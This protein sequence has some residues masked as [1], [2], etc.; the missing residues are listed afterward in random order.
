MHFEI[1]F[2][3]NEKSSGYGHVQFISPTVFAMD[4][5]TLVDCVMLSHCHLG[6]CNNQEKTENAR[7]GYISYFCSLSKWPVCQREVRFFPRLTFCFQNQLT[8]AAECLLHLFFLWPSKMPAL[9]Q[10]A[11][12]SY[13]S[14]HSP[15]VL[16]HFLSWAIC[17]VFTY[18]LDCLW[19]IWPV[20][21]LIEF[22]SMI[23][24]FFLVRY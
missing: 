12:S 18:W 4:A 19:I 21:L 9:L 6:Q 11:V 2:N 23:S 16:A 1:C 13:F 15:H 7:I 17:L 24:F 3:I 5:Q 8:E 20:F 14:E 10:T 22:L